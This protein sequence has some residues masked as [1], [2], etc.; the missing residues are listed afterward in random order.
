MNPLKLD[1][2]L[3]SYIKKNYKV[4]LKHC[5]GEICMFL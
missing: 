1:N 4:Y 5:V 3:N 2:N